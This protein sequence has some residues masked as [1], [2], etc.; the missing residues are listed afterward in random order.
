MVE[1][2]AGAGPGVVGARRADGTAAARPP[3]QGE[4]LCFVGALGGL[5][6][7][8]AEVVGSSDNSGSEGKSSWPSG[9]EHIALAGESWRR[10]R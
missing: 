7:S 10:A 1:A 8:L 6:P 3:G 4:A 9:C 5:P 2:P